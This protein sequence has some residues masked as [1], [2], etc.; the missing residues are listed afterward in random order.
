MKMLY[1]YHNGY[2]P[3]YKRLKKGRFIWPSSGATPQ[4]ISVRELHRLIEGG[5]IAR[6]PPDQSVTYAS[7][8]DCHCG[9][10]DAVLL[11]PFAIGKALLCLLHCRSMNHV[12]ANPAD[13]LKALREQLA[14]QQ[15]SLAEKEA[16]L[17]DKD[18]LLSNKESL[19][20]NHVA[21]APDFHCTLLTAFWLGQANVIRWRV[22]PQLSR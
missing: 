8:Y 3:V 12:A 22:E 2:I 4:C 20:Q 18:A 10:N 13:E 11:M 1:W 7:A 16:L 14:L 5:D 9:S 15:Q 21:L 6:L 17:K 19:L